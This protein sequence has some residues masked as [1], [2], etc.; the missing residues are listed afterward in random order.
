MRDVDDD[1]VTAALG[2]QMLGHFRMKGCGGDRRENASDH[3]S[4]LVLIILVILTVEHNIL[5]IE[6]NKI[7]V[8]AKTR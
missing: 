4:R 5:V 8:E 3:P 7:L 2:N 6:Y 1:R